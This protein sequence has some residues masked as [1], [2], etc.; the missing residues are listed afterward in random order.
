MLRRVVAR[1]GAVEGSAVVVGARA[2]SAVV[3][4]GPKTEYVKLNKH[5]SDAE[6]RINAQPIIYVDKVV[7]VCDGGACR[8]GRMLWGAQRRRAR[9]R[10]LAPVC[11]WCGES[12]GE[13]AC[14]GGGATGHPAV[15]IRLPIDGTPRAC[16]YCGLRYA[17]KHHHNDIAWPDWGNYQKRS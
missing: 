11:C 5:R 17:Q 12:V 9:H 13:C 3:H 2:L 6:D 15:S 16:N 10:G 1:V 7:A 14:A 4:P 8:G